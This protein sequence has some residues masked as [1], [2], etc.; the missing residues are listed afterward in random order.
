V[1]VERKTK[2]GKVNYRKA[3]DAIGM[4]LISAMFI[5]ELPKS[6]KEVRNLYNRLKGSIGAPYFKIDTVEKLTKPFNIRLHTWIDKGFNYRFL[7]KVRDTEVSLETVNEIYNLIDQASKLD[8][9]Y[10]LS[11]YK[12][13]DTN[14]LTVTINEEFLG[15]AKDLISKKVVESKKEII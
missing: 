9:Q 10:L 6:P 15:M 8:L 12:A 13:F 2:Q 7:I 4:Y 1:I 5:Q 11:Y 14:G 3:L